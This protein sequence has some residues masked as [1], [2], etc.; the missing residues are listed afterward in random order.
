ML[1]TEVYPATGDARM[2]FSV[3][4]ADDAAGIKRIR[5]DLQGPSGQVLQAW[6]EFN[7]NFPLNATVQVNTAVLSSLTETGTWNVMVVEIFDDAGNSSSY[8]S[9]DLANQGYPTTLQAR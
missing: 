2:S 3:T 8:I 6:G 4:A 7:A 1:T 9:D 5:V